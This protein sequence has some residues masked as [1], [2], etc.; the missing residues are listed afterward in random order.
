MASKIL[1]TIT[2]YFREGIS[3]KFYNANLEE[4]D[5]EFR[6]TFV[7]GRTGTSG[8]S[9]I[10]G[11]ALTYIESKLMYD[12]LIKEKMA[13]GYKPDANAISYAGISDKIDTGRRPQLL[14]AMDDEKLER[15]LKDPAYGAQEKYDGHR[16]MLDKNPERIISINR[17][18]QQVGYPVILETAA[19]ELTATHFCIDGEE[20]G[21]TFYAYDILSTE[22]QD[23][24]KM[25]Y[26]TRWDFLHSII[27]GNAHIIIA[28]LYFTEV[29][30]RELYTRLVAEKKEGIVFKRL[31]SL[32]QEAIKNDDQVK[33][34]FYSEASCIVTQVNKQRSVALGIY[35]RDQLMSIGNCTIPVNKDIPAKGSIVDIKYLYAYKGGAL[36]QPIFL[37]ERDDISI[38]DCNVSQLKYKVE[39]EEE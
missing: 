39:N 14:K 11:G 2:L 26:I 19:K 16:K 21:N 29:K 10:K 34:K 32:Y 13:K 18:G 33:F 9:G 17:K 28:P 37:K 24:R 15:F 27:K 38:S 36:Y 23:L 5:N 12:R 22:T 30:K 3:D 4:V 20:V 7:Y 8:Q 1:E 6:V 31:D 25:P 35:D